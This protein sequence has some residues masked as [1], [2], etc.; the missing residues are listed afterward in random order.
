MTASFF[1]FEGM[2]IVISK[3]MQEGGPLEPGGF[4]S[5]GVLMTKSVRG[6]VIGPGPGLIKL[7]FDR[8]S[9]FPSIKMS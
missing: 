2:Y 6:M 3:R 8:D 5:V 9:G 4:E 7:N 1:R